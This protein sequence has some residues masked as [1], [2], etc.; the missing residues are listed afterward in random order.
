[1]KKKLVVV[2][3]QSL[4]DRLRQEVARRQVAE[5]LGRDK[6]NMSVLITQAIE[7]QLRKGS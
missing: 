5:G 3:E 2:L 7:K 4:L 6:I 1:M